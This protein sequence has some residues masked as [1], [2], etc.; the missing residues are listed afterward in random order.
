MGIRLRKPWQPLTE[1]AVA[2]L[3]GQ[4]GVYEIGDAAGEVARIGFAGGREP[5]GLRSALA[6]ELE[7]ATG[8]LFR[9]EVN[10]QYL[11]RFQELLMVHVADHGC[12]PPD[13]PEPDLRLGRLSP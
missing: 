9:Y 8:P 1:E 5:F 4:L 10:Q 13:Q 11:T 3:S 12:L 7:A 2:E 6:A